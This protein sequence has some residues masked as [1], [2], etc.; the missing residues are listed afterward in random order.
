MSFRT[1]EDQRRAVEAAAVENAKRKTI[2]EVYAE[3]QD[4]S[5]LASSIQ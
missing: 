5:P 3:H 1:V 2:A 4:Y